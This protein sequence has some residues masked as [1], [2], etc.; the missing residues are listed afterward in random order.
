MSRSV[1]MTAPTRTAP[2]ATVPLTESEMK[3]HARVD[4]SNEDALAAVYVASAVEHLDGRAG[5]LGR[6]LITQTWEVSLD[7]FPEDVIRLPLGPAQSVTDVAYYDADN[8]E[9][10]LASS[11]YRL[12]HDA[13]GPYLRRVYGAEWPETYDRDD[14]VTVTWQAGYGDAATDVPE[15]IRQAIRL[16]SAH[17]FEMREPAAV[18]ASVAEV[19][20]SVA[21]L[22]APYR[23]RG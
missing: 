19:P 6:A 2:P 16:L 22:I 9:Q 15:A 4:F 20:M 18:G 7:K 8:A 5:L 21:A 23:R 13:R 17:W 1:S 3:S 11:T 12:H 10:T 14:A